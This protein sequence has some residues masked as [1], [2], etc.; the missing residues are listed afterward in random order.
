MR[1]GVG[2]RRHGLG[3]QGVG[4]VPTVSEQER[5]WKVSQF[6]VLVSLWGSVHP[7]PNGYPREREV[8]EFVVPMNNCCWSLFLGV[9]V[10]HHAFA[11]FTQI[12]AFRRGKSMIPQTGWFIF[13]SLRGT[14]RISILRKS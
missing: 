8:I 1:G 14:E 4:L 13:A 11:I 12:L 9:V 6:S 5:V 7:E 2:Q 3:C 10:S